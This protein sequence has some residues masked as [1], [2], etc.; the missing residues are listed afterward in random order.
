MKI[1]QSTFCQKTAEKRIILPAMGNG[2]GSAL[3]WFAG[4]NVPTEEKRN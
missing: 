1:A 2:E 4:A 3:K